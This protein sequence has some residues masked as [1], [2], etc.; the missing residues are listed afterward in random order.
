[1]SNL[2]SQNKGW[3]FETNERKYLDEVLSSGFGAGESGTFNERLE[4]MFADMHNQR[5]AI[6]ANS[7]TSTLHMGLYAGG[8]KAGDEV[9]IPTIGPAMTG[10]SVWQSGATPV[11]VDAR[12]D[13][14]L[15]DMNDARKK[16]TK[17]TK[18]IMPVHIYGLMCDMTAVL[19]LAEEFNLHIV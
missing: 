6:T 10:Y 12:V 8:I 1:M 15:M 11:Y 5:Y 17:K 13:T 9:L 4:R 19:A 14:F 3:R 2:I 16:I 18:A 7:G